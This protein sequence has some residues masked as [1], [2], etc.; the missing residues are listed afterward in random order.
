MD[1]RNESVHPD[2][3]DRAWP[4]TGPTANGTSSRYLHTLRYTGWFDHATAVLLGR[5]NAPNGNADAENPGL[6]QR[7]AVLDALGGLDVP[8]VFDLEIGH[9]PPHLPLLNG[10]T[11]HIV[12]DDHEHSITQHWR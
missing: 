8:L 1:S 12:I 10:A 2:H 11:A 9:V 3:L 5:T 6:T 4:G 7:D